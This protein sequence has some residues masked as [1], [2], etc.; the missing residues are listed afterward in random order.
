M[1]SSAR[2]VAAI[3]LSVTVGRIALAQS[4][5]TDST[6]PKAL[7]AMLMYTGAAV[8]DA[9]GG[10][11][12]G[13]VVTG[14][15]AAQFTIRLRRL[16]GWHG[17]QAFVYVLGTHGG[18]PSDMA[19]DIQGVSNLE[20]PGGVRLEEAWLQQNML[21]NRVS[22]LVGRYDLS[23][24][25]YFTRSGNLFLNG[26]PGMGP[27]L[28]LSG[29]EGPSSYPFTAVGAR[30]DVK[31]TTNS[32]VRGAVLDGVP[33][34]RPGG[35]IHLFAPG[36]GLLLIGEVALLSRPDTNARLQER[37]FLI[38]RG[39]PRPYAGKVAAGAWYYTARFPDLVDTVPSGGA[40]QR[41]GNGGAYVI[42]DQTI[43]RAPRGGPAMLT[44]YVQ[45]GVGDPRVYQ[46][47]G[48]RGGGVT[49]TAPF[50][51]R[52]QDEVGIAI[53]AA[54][55]GSHFVRAEALNDVAAP[56]ETALELTY[57]AQ[58]TPWLIVQP[59]LQRVFNPGGTAVTR[60]AWVL[61]LQIEVSRSF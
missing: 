36:D 14:A 59:D 38:G 31:P 46:V 27:E 34:D 58:L 4:G 57:A 22:L 19:G 13:T 30:L 3:A 10:V 42:A 28:G 15:A 45:L 17:A 29:V 18:A 41:H 11:R 25:F 50:P 16:I 12:R 33:V 53:A 23:T 35:G 49:M 20:A 9:S 6:S 48:Y 32:V 39:V 40:V 5:S 43:W 2:R 24:E 8:N 51:K 61:T 47:G 56:N 60:N 21:D 54:R 7:S 55:N 52:S 1:N 26:S 44:A 37:H